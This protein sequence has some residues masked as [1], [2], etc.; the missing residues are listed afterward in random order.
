MKYKQCTQCH[1]TK[2]LNEENFYVGTRPGKTYFRTPCKECKR[3]TSLQWRNHNILQVKKD[4]AEWR[5]A[6]PGYKKHYSIQNKAYLQCYRRKYESLPY[7]RLRKSVSHSIRQHLLKAGR[8]KSGSVF[9]F[10]PYTLQELK[11]HL[12]RQFES[13]MNWGNNGVYDP[14][15]WDDNDRSTWFWQIDHIIP[16]SSFSYSSLENSQ[17]QECWALRNLRP[18]NAKQNNKDGARRA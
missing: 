2:E 18:L 13:W 17:F 9:D 4:Q 11:E 10:L 5:A 7:I 16:H 14:K 8:R 12:E 1:K 3:K 6:N 15:V